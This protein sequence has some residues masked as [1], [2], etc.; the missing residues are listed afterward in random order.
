MKN[1]SKEKF[2]SIYPT[3]IFFF[4]SLVIFSGCSASKKSA[5]K[6]VEEVIQ[7][8]RSYRGTPYRYGGT[9]RAG[10]DCSAL[11]YQSFASIGIQMPRTSEGQSKLG[12]NVAEKNLQK[13]DLV[14]FA[15]SKSRKK[16]THSGI[17]TEVSGK[18]IYFIHSSTSLG[19]TED[20]LS[21]TYWN[22]AFLFG[23]RILD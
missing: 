8:A 7:T 6:N 19:V 17:V 3:F 11:I 4:L 2:S 20:N 14:F 13:G 9:T 5:S 12:K 22:K 23:K 16:V 1:W 18:G 10:M 15:T 21:S